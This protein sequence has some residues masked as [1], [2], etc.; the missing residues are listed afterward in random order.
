M[1]ETIVKGNH[2]EKRFFELV[3]HAKIMEVLCQSDSGQSIHL[4]EIQIRNY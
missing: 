4:Y 2:C 1:A 3:R